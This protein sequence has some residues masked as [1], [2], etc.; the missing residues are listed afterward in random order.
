MVVDAARAGEARTASEVAVAADRARARR[1]RG[2][3]HEPARGLP[4]R[5]FAAGRGRAAAGE[6]SGA[7]GGQALTPDPS[8]S[9]RGGA[10]LLPSARRWP[11]APDEGTPHA[12]PA[13]LLASAYP[14]RIA[15]ARGKRGEFL[16]AN[17]RAAA[18]EPHDAL[19]GE[20]FL[21]IGEI[22]G[23][24]ASARILLAAPLTLEDIEAVAAA[25]IET[26]DELDLRPRL[27]LVARAPAPPARRARPR[28]ADARRPA[29][30][31][32]A[33]ALARG[34]LSL[35][36]RAPAVDQ[37]A[38]A[39]ARPGHVSAPRRGRRCGPTFPTAAL[40]ASRMAGAVS[41]GQDAS[42]RNRRRRP[43]RRRCM[44]DSLMTWRGGWMRRRRPIPCA[45]RHGSA[46]RLRS[47]GRSCDRAARAGVVRPRR[48]P[49]GRRRTHSA[50]PSPAFAGPPADPDHA[51]PA[52]LLARLLGRRPVR[53]ARPLPPPHLAATAREAGTSSARPAFCSCPFDVLPPVMRLLE[54]QHLARLSIRQRRLELAHLASERR[55]RAEFCHRFAGRR[56]EGDGVVG[57][58]EHLEA[59]AVL[60]AGRAGR[61]RRDRARRCSSRRCACATEG[62]RGKR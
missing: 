36:R 51:R 52:G 8:P 9:G 30:R 14:D 40:A 48:A 21:A 31:R 57:R 16:M 1:R 22:A 44:R 33:L 10:P 47:R 6:G 60:F 3:S 13:R 59:K 50:D 28:R 32:S 54:P 53:S 58:I 15:M 42:R 49:V 37:G 62:R 27:R 55:V 24:A 35:G 38:Q 20:P 4:P 2:R 7:E 29:G 26:A 41:P 34:V 46:D 56:V 25:S 19:A 5:P 43:R 12:I 61:S 18:L 11:E 39:M 23:R 45:D 17:G